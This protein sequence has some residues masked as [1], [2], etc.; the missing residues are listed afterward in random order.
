MDTAFASEK[1]DGSECFSILIVEDEEPVR[2]LL[3]S[4]LGSTYACS[5][6][7]NAEQAIRHLESRDFDLIVT[8][9]TMP[10]ISGLEL[11]KILKESHPDTPVLITSGLMGDWYRHQAMANGAHGFIQKPFDLPSLMILV[12]RVLKHSQTESRP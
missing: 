6:A 4:C 7:N 10:G 11:C 5:T 12:D 2:Q 8:D 3:V 9:I 1:L